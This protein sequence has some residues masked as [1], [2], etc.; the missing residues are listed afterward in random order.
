MVLAAL[1]AALS[2]ANSHAFAN[3]A[4]SVV[5][6]GNSFSSSGWSVGWA[7]GTPSYNG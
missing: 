4:L 1:L 5:P 2:P 7:W 3:L 6:A